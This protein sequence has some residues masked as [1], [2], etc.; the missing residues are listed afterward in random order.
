MDDLKHVTA[1]FAD[2]MP[3]ALLLKMLSTYINEYQESPSKDNFEKV[4]G[5]CMLVVKKQAIEDLGGIGG[6]M[7]QFDEFEEAHKVFK[8]F[9]NLQ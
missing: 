2:G 1:I 6:F 4:V 5:M 3:K 9:T 8:N 7:K